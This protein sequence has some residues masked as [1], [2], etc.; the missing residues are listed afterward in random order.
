MAENRRADAGS[1][2]GGTPAALEAFAGA[3]ARVREGAPLEERLRA[4]AEA[5]AGATHADTAV[6][7]LLDAS[8]EVLTARAVVSASPALAAQLEGS[9]VAAAAAAEL[10]DPGRLPEPLGALARGAGIDAVLHLPV[11]AGDRPVGTLELW[12]AGGPFDDAER[13]LARVAAG[14]ASL[15]AAGANGTERAAGALEPTRLAPLGDALAAAAEGT[16]LGPALV[17]LAARAA[18]AV[19]AALWEE[20]ESG[21]LRRTACA[22]VETVAL[23]PAPTADADGPAVVVHGGESAS[24]VTLRLGDPAAGY[25]QL[26]FVAQSPPAALDALATFGARAGQALRASRRVGRT[27]VELERSR[28]LLAVVGQAIAELSLSHTLETAVA[29]V[30]ELLR[31]SRVAVY[32]REQGGL[33]TAAERGVGPRH[34]VLAG[35]LFELAVGPVRGRRVIVVDSD[36]TDRRLASARRVWEEAGG[37]AVVAMPLAVHEDVIGLLVAYLDPGRSPSPDERALLAA[38]AAQLGV[39]VQNALL[40]EEAKELGAARAR[41]LDA[42]RQ[43]AKQLRAFYEIS[44]SFT[45]SL[46]LEETLEAVARTAVELLDADA[47]VLRGHD[48]RRGTLLADAV[49]VA[50]EELAPAVRA[51]LA[52]PQSLTTGPGR[53]LAESREPV[54]LTPERAGALGESYELLAPFLERGATAAVVPV[55]AG[56]EL[57][58]IL[59]VVSLDAE[60]PLNAG[61][62]AAARS[63]AGHAALALDNARLYQQQQHFLEAMQRSLLPESL[64]EATGL[65]L[66]LAYESSARLEVG[67]DV[68]DFVELSNG[69]LGVVLGDVTGHGVEA[70]ADMAMAKYV[71]RSLAREHPQPGAVLAAMNEVIVDE[72]AFGKFITLAYLTADGGSGD[73]CCAVA[74]HPPPRVVRADRVEE[75]RVRGVALGVEPDQRYEQVG[76]SLAHGESVVLYTD[77]IVEARSDE[78]FYGVERVD[79]VLAAHA[80]APAAALAEAVLADSRAFVDGELQ[81]DC[82]VVVVKRA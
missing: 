46:S 22:G 41:A 40:H 1:D 53:A 17:R 67:G 29:R 4:L 78:E 81:D 66:G 43:A 28:A 80:Q 13:L 61:S 14:Q 51:I 47:A 30:S 54:L 20:D 70:A 65:E 34:D 16:R 2:G 8:A 77:G 5:V 6:V 23:L 60:R 18:G 48:A 45:R 64:P 19:G 37:G 24:G 49:H 58:A 39:A 32:L 72:L 10:D 9:R 63:L 11:V 12:R 55:A 68:Y 50:D 62:L 82:A 21:E 44:Q 52:R 35:E 7:R 69:R 74:G 42:E 3:A 15:I 57:M 36:T 59:T 56:E 31:T 33:R 71:F 26:A 38:L 76:A 27:A 75:L 73:V 25:L 79:A